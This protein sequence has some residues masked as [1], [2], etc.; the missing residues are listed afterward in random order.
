[1]SFSDRSATPREET[2]ATSL[3]RAIPLALVLACGVAFSAVAA[4]VVRNQEIDRYEGDFERHAQI[5]WRSIQV[6]IREYEECLHSLRDLFD[7]S[8]HVTP[9][10]FRR[11]SLDL[12]TRHP[13]IELVAWL[14][15]VRGVDRV[16]FENRAVRPDGIRFPIHD[17]ARAGS[18]G[19]P[20]PAPAREEYLPVEF[21]E[22]M[23]GYENL[24][25]LDFLR[26]PYLQ[27]ITR[28]IDSDDVSATRSIALG[29]AGSTDPGWACALPVFVGEGEPTS[30][31][32]RRQR[33]RGIL[34]GAISF[35]QLL[36]NS[37][38]QVSGSNLD[39]MLVDESAPRGERFL[40]G[41]VGGQ[42]RT[43]DLESG[44]DFR[45]GLH[46]VLPLAVA[47]RHWIAMFR[48]NSQPTSFYPLAFL[49]GGIALTTML[50]ALLYS[51][52]QRTLTVQRLVNERT[53]ELH[54]TQRTL[55]DDN[56]RRR[57]AEERY[58]AFVEQSSEAIWRFE[59]SEA[60][61]IDLPEDEQIRLYYERAFLAEANDAFAQM[62]GFERAKEMIGM[63]LA[64]LMPRDRATFEHLRRYVRSGYRLSN[65]ESHEVGRNGVKCI[66][67]NNLTGI[68][69]NGRLVRAWGT[70][71]DVTEQRMAED[72]RQR[73]EIRL[74]SA[75]AAANLGTWEWEV[76]TDTI[77]WSE[78][79]ERMFGFEPGTFRGG[80]SDYAKLVHPD[81][82]ADVEA[83]V[84]K[85]A[86][87]G[88]SLSGELR[89]VRR[90]GTERWIASRGD[91]IRDESGAIV[92][93][94][95]AVMDVTEQH[96]AA[97]EKAQIE[98]RLQETQKLESLGILAGG[99]AHDF[100][101][102]LTGILGNT[103][104]AQ[105]D[106]PETSP[107]QENL[108]AIEKTSRRAAEL[109][110][111]MLAYSGKGRFVVQRLDLEEIVRDTTQLVRPSLGRHAVLEFQLAKGLPSISADATQMRQIIMN[112]VINASDALG[113]KPG[114]ITL[115]TGVIDADAAYL[116]TTAMSPDVP[117]GRFVF[118]EIAD[119]GEGMSA[120]V[121]TKIFNPFFTTKFTGRGLGLAAVLGIVRG[122]GGAIKVTSKV[123]EGS[124]FRLL[125]PAI[126]GAVETRA[127]E[128]PV[129]AEWRGAGTVLVADDEP[130]VRLV[131]SRL[132]ES[133]G[134]RVVLAA[135][136][137]EALEAFRKSP[138]DFA[139]VLLDLTMPQMDGMEAF[140]AMR[141]IR[142]DLPVVLMSGYTEQDAVSRF[143]GQ[144]LAGF[145]Q[146]PF[147]PAELREAFSALTATAAA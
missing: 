3:R 33:L 15:R 139:A 39:V 90:D 25:G 60:V 113:E 138:D 142:A 11:A 29:R 51:A 50:M 22:P 76:A 122:H 84:R 96:V 111:Q 137:L 52:Q 12:R 133:F 102:L 91:V 121:M 63:S 118:L 82:R 143:A 74:R 24:F 95:G 10:E 14:P 89:I 70:Q 54:M 134:F 129:I 103:S 145:V 72:Q 31:D 61:P 40:A 62:Y 46:R 80:L 34:A 66:F 116:A 106:L 49:A 57:N 48:P 119:T 104:L 69:E 110:K 107:V 28:A 19:P 9:G 36:T 141:S 44:E 5:E 146:K 147:S 86:R 68:V 98:R 13:G 38:G 81:E 101:N 94:I 35:R 132:L 85:V 53:S 30:V 45:S 21:I 97:D 112:L 135:N 8:D 20:V 87:E 59:L 127:P 55:H 26:P 130:S 124:T 23:S 99:V 105:M 32:E 100:N 67:I 65:A 108:A 41:L 2:P 64:D 37:V 58:R 120:E 115:T 17:G 47:G 7:S 42:V 75:L 117:P 4:L 27:T 71:R 79:T 88:G 131:A 128:P 73:A 56:Q 140:T 43:V 78:T 18:L 1:M 6:A 123:G 77:A 109:C 136:G 83:H 114:V 125:L 92:R 16:T 144:G 126:E 93:L